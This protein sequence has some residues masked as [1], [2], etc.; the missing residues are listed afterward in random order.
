M[1]AY[2]RET[3]EPNDCLSLAAEL[4]K[5]ALE[6][7]RSRSEDDMESTASDEVLSLDG[8]GHAVRWADAR[9]D[10]PRLLGR[11]PKALDVLREVHF[12]EK[13]TQ[14][15]P[16]FSREPEKKSKT[17]KTSNS[18]R[19]SAPAQPASCLMQGPPAR[20]LRMQPSRSA[21]SL[22]HHN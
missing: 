19:E 4:I 10:I 6:D 8:D 9:P 12:R 7:A 15:T 18:K 14:S 1:L 11:E 5:G 20:S 3:R 2:T 16:N 22:R 21:G 17:S 13:S